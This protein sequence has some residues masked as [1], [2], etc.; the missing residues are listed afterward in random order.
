[1]HKSLFPV[2]ESACVGVR[3]TA[4][5]HVLAPLSSVEETH[6]FREKRCARRS[7]P[8]LTPVV[9]LRV[10]RSKNVGSAEGD[11]ANDPAAA[12]ANLEVGAPEPLEG[13]VAT[14]AEGCVELFGDEVAR[15]VYSKQWQHREEGL[16]RVLQQLHSASSSR[17]AKVVGSVN[18]KSL[19][20]KNP[21]VYMVAL[22]LFRAAAKLKDESGRP[23][24]VKGVFD[25]LMPLVIAQLSNNNV[26]VKD[27]T[28]RA[29]VELSQVC[30]IV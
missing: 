10:H 20:D 22:N 15:M 5:G 19:N 6:S 24:E 17:A 7:G 30:F 18:K 14:E 1:M 29:L 27:D 3:T 28:A 23:L 21:A 13:A 26:R 9:H 2:C 25:P 4:H 11:L 16:K 12:A 8:R